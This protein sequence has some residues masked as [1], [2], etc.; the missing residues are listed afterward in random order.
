MRETTEFGA[1]IAEFEAIGT[2]VV[3]VSVDPVEQ[4][5]KHAIQCAA[6]FPIVSDEDQK[7]TGELGI[8]SE[9][10]TA[11]RTTYVI[12]RTGTVRNVFEGVRVD[13]HVDQVLEAAKQLR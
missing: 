10:G 13:G 5:K 8:L 7:L 11:Q 4:E 3:G 12:D 2:K 1:R 9:R 6:S